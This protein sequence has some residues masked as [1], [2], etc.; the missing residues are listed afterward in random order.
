MSQ[1]RWEELV[2]DSVGGDVTAGTMFGSKGLR[3]GKKFFAI[4]WHEQLVLKLPP[5]QIEQLVTAGNGALFEPMEGRQMNGW[6]V[7]APG[8]DWTAL[9][10]DAR[11][12]VVSQQR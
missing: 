12:F 8:T 5:A 1:Q 10:I 6:V 9:S 4:W 3:T 11:D 7:V 2:E